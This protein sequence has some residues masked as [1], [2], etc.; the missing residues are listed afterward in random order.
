MWHHK[1]CRK[2]DA[3]M[4]DREFTADKLCKDHDIKLIRPPFLKEKLQF[5][6]EEALLG[7]EIAKARVHI[8]RSNQRLKTFKVLNC[9]MPIGLVKKGEQIFTIICGIVNLSSPI[10]KNDKFN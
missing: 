9:R 7:A 1:L 6:K 5:S 8:E 10:L 2:N 4:V 3:I